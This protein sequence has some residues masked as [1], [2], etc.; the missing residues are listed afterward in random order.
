MAAGAWWFGVLIITS[1][2]TA[3][4]AAFLTIKDSADEISSVEDLASR[5]SMKYG[6][7]RDTDVQELFDT[8][9]RDPYMYVL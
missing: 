3:N 8:A 4:L 9:T 1:S 7:V 5:V 6:T 2:Y